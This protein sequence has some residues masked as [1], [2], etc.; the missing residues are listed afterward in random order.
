M[1]TEALTIGALL[2][3]ML[4]QSF[5]LTATMLVMGPAIAV[6]VY[7]VGMRYRRIHKSIQGSVG[8]LS[9]VAEQALSAQHE[10]KVYGAQEQ[11]LSRFAELARRNQLLNIKVQATQAISSSLVQFFAACALAAIVYM[12]GR[13]AVKEGMT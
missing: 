1:I 6:V 4:Y 9:H 10:V 2:A 8:D 7:V 12:A 11:E 13:E 5:K 3:V